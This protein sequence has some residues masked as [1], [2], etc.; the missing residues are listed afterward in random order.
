MTKAATV[1][2]I[3]GIELL[4]ERNLLETHKSESKATAVLQ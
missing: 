2:F 4:Y 1:D 3:A